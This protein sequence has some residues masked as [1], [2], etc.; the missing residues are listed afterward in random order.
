MDY[1]YSDIRGALRG[2]LAEEQI[3]D[4][5]LMRDIYARDASY[6][7]I[8]PQVIVRPRTAGEVAQV[9]A[10]ARRFGVGVTMRAAG[11]SLSGQT[12]G[13]GIICELRTNFHDCRVCDNGKRVWFEPGLT[14][15]QVNDIL[16]PY[17]TKLGPDPASSKAAMMGGVLANNS[18]GMQAGV[19]FNSYHTLVSMEFM[20]ANG[21]TYNS[22]VD[23]D[24][25]RFEREES[26]LCRG[27][28]EIRREILAD[29]EVKEKVER[30]YRI[31]NVTGYAM[32]SFTDYDKPIDIFIH[33]LIGSEGTL[34]HI[35]SAELNTRPLCSD[36]SSSMLYFDSVVSAAATAKQLG[37]SGALAVELM[38]Y[39]SLRAS[40]GLSADM[41][42]GT[43]AMLIDYG[44]FSREALDAKL[45]DIEPELRKLKGLIHQEA[46]TTTEAARA[47]LWK[48]RDGVFPCVAGVR[49]P[50]STVILEDIVAPVARLDEMVEGVQQLF[51]SHGYDG[52]IFGHARDGNM[53]PLVTGTL[54][55]EKSRTN[56]ADF[57]ERFVDLV[58]GLDGSLKGEHGTGRAMAP[59]V[60]REWGA[61]IYDM[62]RRVKKLADPQ[63]ILNPG[64]IINDDPEAFIKPIKSLDLFGEAMGYMEA[65]RCME[66]G[67]C[68]HCCP[69]R[70]VTL[71]PRQRLQAQRLMASAAARHDDEKLKSYRKTYKYSGND[72]CCTDGTCSIQCPLGIN[73]AVV[74]DAVR[75]ENNG[76]LF[77]KALTF[78]ASRYGGA[79]KGIRGMLR[80]GK[81]AEKVVTPKPLEWITSVAHDV[82]SQIP[83]WSPNFPKPARIPWQTTE[84]PDFIYFPAC[85]T[86]IFGG[87]NLGK[88]DLIT[89]ME[90]LG[91]RAGFKLSVPKEFEGVCCSQIW[92]HKGDKAG[93]IT[94]ANRAVEEFYRQSDG[95]RIPIVCDTTSC[96]HTL[97]TMAKENA[98]QHILTEENAA[99][100]TKL[101]FLDITQWLHDYVMPRVEVKRK[102]R[103]V[104]LH[105]TCASKLLNLAPLMVEV[106]RQCAEKVTL[107]RN[108][109]CCGSGGDRGFLFPEVVRTATRPEKEAIGDA[110][111][112]GYYSLARTCEISMTGT[113]GKPY[114]SIAY[115][116]DETTA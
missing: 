72:T 17:G 109:F 59:F 3:F 9:L 40:Q 54:D 20:L 33:L 8:T 34:A 97:L 61:K 66:C 76:S 12:L 44:D 15:N 95:G 57:I 71:T 56:F 79:V 1:C 82:Y 62:M 50:G 110:D 41:P 23:S 7:N 100:L 63:G 47:A 83:H 81:A 68:E 14:V 70:F 69:S 93:E 77:D 30:K 101:K 32:N 36:Y 104:C 78:S 102:K 115:L 28:M 27:L 39:G 87:S 29:Q 49:D 80:L 5:D 16:R 53:H 103:S 18:S 90:R 55:S 99:K 64:V 26:E 116:V 24:R 4:N 46:F 86:R 2:F 105:P 92:E 38:D 58:V 73:T 13:C 48:L 98:S 111:F 84:N 88:D 75:R 108:Q 19:E 22:A 65:D 43:T 52:A 37:D 21:H 113:I 94:M 96:T 112:D 74:T 107:P 31:K 67:Y 51:K 35:I 25:I 114:E 10:T 11:T 6:F 91:R 42:A 45:R 85:V 60:E 89:V 106:A